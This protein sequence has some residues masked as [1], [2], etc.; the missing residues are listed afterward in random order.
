M[1]TSGS[2][3]SGGYQGR[4]LRFEWGT[5]NIN[6]ADNTRSIWYKM[7]VEVHLTIIIIMKLLILTVTEYI[8]V[9]THIKFIQMMY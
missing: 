7:L 9:A 4:V 8:Q 5:N 2:V 1:A 3:D 6:S